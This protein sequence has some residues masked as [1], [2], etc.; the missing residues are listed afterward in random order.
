VIADKGIMLTANEPFRVCIGI[1]HG[2]MLYSETLEGYFAKEMN[3]ASKLGE[4]TANG[5]ETLLTES[6]YELATPALQAHFTPA[7]TGVSGLDLN[8]YRHTSVAV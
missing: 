7:H 5:C 2:A 4:D 3:F 8:Y 6:A 1:G